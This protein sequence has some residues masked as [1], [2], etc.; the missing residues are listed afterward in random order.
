MPCHPRDPLSTNRS[1][2]CGGQRRGGF[3][4]IELATVIGIAMVLI[5]S[6]TVATMPMLRRAAFN[7]ALGRLEDLSR[8]ARH[9]ARHSD[10]QAAFYGVVVKQDGN[11]LRASITRGANPSSA[12]I[13]MGA[14]GAPLA[15]V[16]LGASLR[17]H[18][19]PSHANANALAPGAEVGW[20]FRSGDGALAVDTARSLTPAFAGVGS[21]DLASAGIIDY[22]L[23]V[24]PA[25]S[26]RTVDGRR[27]TA[28]AIYGIGVFGTCPLMGP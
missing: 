2:H 4:A 18:L 23:A 28:I 19:G 9:L 27:A 11:H 6:G 8:Q 13:A 3:T 15:E 20:M 21:G 25:M 17:L 10:D 22:D 5:S 1:L 16:D 26:V 12:T 7:Q 24:S 14:S